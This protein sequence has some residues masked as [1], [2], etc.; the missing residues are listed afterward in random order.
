MKYD[1]D[2]KKEELLKVLLDV[3][4]DVCPREFML[5]HN[6]YSKIPFD[7]YE[8]ISVEYDKAI[9]KII[10]PKKDIKRI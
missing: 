4:N 1:Y 7:T 9:H 10:Y 6:V 5:D 8:K 2:F 3:F